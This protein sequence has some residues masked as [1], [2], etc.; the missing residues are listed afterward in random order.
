MNVARSIKEKRILVLAIVA[1][2]V[3][4]IINLNV[5][6]AALVITG[7][8]LRE[9]LSILPAVF[10]LSALIGAWVSKETIMR[11]FGKDSGVRGHIASVVMGSISAGPIYAAFPLAQSLL[12]KGAS[13]ANTIII[14]SSWAV[15]KAPM[16]FVEAKFFGFKFTLTRYLLTLPAILIMGLLGEKFLDRKEVLAAGE[17]VEIKLVDL[18]PGANCKACGYSSCKDYAD[19]IE[20]EDAALDKC[21]VGGDEVK[22]KLNKFLHS[23]EN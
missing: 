7:G 3:T 8:F 23:A 20:K 13:L 18:L 15:I 11:Y 17:Q 21:I 5:A 9:M 1:Y 4:A 6:K 19:A 14:I 16:L 10:V 22:K 12:Q 2:I